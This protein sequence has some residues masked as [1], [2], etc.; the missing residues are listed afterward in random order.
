MYTTI[1]KPGVNRYLS[2]NKKSA[3]EQFNQGVGG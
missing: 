1:L 2:S 3:K